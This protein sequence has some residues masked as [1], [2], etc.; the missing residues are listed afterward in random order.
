MTPRQQRLYEA[1]RECLARE[2]AWTPVHLAQGT[3]AR[4]TA[5]V[6]VGRRH[7]P[8]YQLRARAACI[9]ADAALSAAELVYC[10]ERARNLIGVIEEVQ[11][12]EGEERDAAV[13]ALLAELAYGPES[14]ETVES[15][16]RDSLGLRQWWGNLRAAI[17][18]VRRLFPEGGQ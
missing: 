6:A 3:S 4:A 18:E 16:G 12:E 11:R 7:S 5:D 15:Y 1:I 10:E 2:A 14:A 17:A 8:D 13:R 9:A